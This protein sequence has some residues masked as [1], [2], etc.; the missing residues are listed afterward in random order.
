MYTLNITHGSTVLEAAKVR[1]V[2]SCCGGD[3][4]SIGSVC[5]SE[6]TA[7]IVGTADLLDE[8]I[9]LTATESG[10]TTNLGT[11]KVT[12][13]QQSGSTTD[14]TA[15]DAAYYA[16]GGT[17]VP[18]G[19]PTTAL[20]VLG[21]ICTQTGLTLDYSGSDVAI[22][23]DLAGHTMR[24]M[25]GYMAALLG[26]NAMIGRDGKLSI[27]WFSAGASL[28]ADDYYSGGLQLDGET[29]LAGIR[30]TK[31]VRTTTT[32]PDTGVTTEEDSTVTYDANDGGSGTVI[33]V[34]N[35]FATQAIVN[36]VWA[37]IRGLG[38]YRT[39]TV[40]Y[41]GGILHEAGDLL[42]VT[43]LQGAT[44]T[45][46]VMAITLEL[47]GGC[48]A[49]A[50]AR[51]QSQTATAANVQGPTGRALSK[52]AADLGEF[53]ELTADNFTATM[54]RIANLFVNDLTLSN[55]LHS[56]DFVAGANGSPFA[57]SGM[58]IDF[59]RKWIQAPYFAIDQY[60]YMYA[61]GGNV[62]GFSIGAESLTSYTKYENEDQFEVEVEFTLLTPN[63]GSSPPGAYFYPV[64]AGTSYDY[65]TYA[66]LTIGG[67]GTRATGVS[68]FDWT[69]IFATDM[70]QNLKSYIRLWAKNR[71][72]EIGADSVQLD[73]NLTSGGDVRAKTLHIARSDGVNPRLNFYRGGAT[74]P[75][76]AIIET[77]DGRL[78]ISGGLV[79]NGSL[80]NGAYS[81]PVAQRGTVT[82][83]GVTSTP[84][85]FSVTFDR[86]FAGVPHIDLEPMRNSN[87]KL[88]AKIKSRTASGFTADVWSESSTALSINVD[89]LAIYC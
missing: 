4:I 9:A 64:G 22:S 8:V 47:D 43:D 6:L 36:A 70:M 40:A 57:Q 1:I 79:V 18:S 78:T 84:V 20:G 39:G 83:A 55:L 74:S 77:A 11:Y 86:A 5:A 65:I 25:V 85:E 61:A 68:A 50:E 67:G 58:G 45:V 42:S 24:E 81:V 82:V 66:G 37:K 69:E 38:T 60:G 53:K 59:G 54:A 14:I 21:D 27:R 62:G 48:K 35:P 29:T 56:T 19:S 23:G 3:A 63:S 2:S 32:D 41:Y 13:C 76:S 49:T 80:L 10:Q 31:T 34:D 17:C 44:S 72:I 52:L 12:A 73:G 75:T 71:L 51:G 15:Y 46:P 89:W 30:M 26:C 28:T 33:A 87:L 88:Y 16:L 7:T